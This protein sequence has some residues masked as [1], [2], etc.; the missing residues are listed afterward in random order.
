VQLIDRML[1][2]FIAGHPGY[3][4]FTIFSAYFSYIMD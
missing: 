4:I 2:K 1:L 3:I